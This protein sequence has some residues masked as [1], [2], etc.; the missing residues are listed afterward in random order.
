MT[1]TSDQTQSSQPTHTTQ[2]LISLEQTYGAHNY[3]PLPI[4]FS[5]AAG[6]KVWD[7]EGNDYI[8]CLSAYS[9]VNQG[10]CH[11]KII[12]ALIHQAQTLT[13]ASRA[14][15][16]SNLGLFS[17][18]ISNTFGYESMLPVNTGVEAVETALKLAR[19]WAYMKKG[20]PPGK[21]IIIS[22]DGNFHGR[23]L[24]VIGMSTDPVALEG[25]GPFLESI[26]SRCPRSS[27]DDNRLVRYNVLS[28]LEAA[29]NAHGPHTAAVLLEP[30]QGEAGVFVPDDDY[31][32]KVQ[33]LCRDH[34][35]L[36]IIDEVQTGLGRTGKLLCQHHHQGLRA[37]IVTLGKALSGGVYPVS[38][39][40]ADRKIMDVIRPGEHGS[41][42]G[43]NPLACAVATAAI[44]VLIDEKMME[45]AEEMG[46]LLRSGLEKLKTI[47]IDGKECQPGKGWI[48]IVRGKGL[49]NAIVI[50]GTESKKK[51]GAWELCLL[52]K[53]KGVLA[54]P[55]HGDIVRL[56]PPLVI[57]QEE[58][59]IVVNV[60]GD[61][62]KELDLVET[63]PS[64]EIDH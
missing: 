59:Q 58:I 53:S 25:F 28:D 35:V 22:A 29:L 56:A 44:D 37:D 50:N 36:L 41:T 24:G 45:R 21:A 30:I 16:N 12:Q 52:M 42:F 47:G 33:K 20:V 32:L 5:R 57:S 43:G 23:T 34:N 19:K 8:D 18:K 49:L 27:G 31:L 14:F 13:L 15:Y 51:R 2:E 64:L 46:N 6:C 60:I 39:I 11:P 7:P 10:H 48:R 61:C 17:Q 62:L 9:A 63:I 55:T 26:G 38:A 3:H 54:K 1:S 40:L 4:V